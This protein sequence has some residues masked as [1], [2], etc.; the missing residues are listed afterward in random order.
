MP[1]KEP[2]TKKKSNNSRVIV[3]AVLIVVVIGGGI[4]GSVYFAASSKTVYIDNAQI[5]APVVD[6]GPNS[7]GILQAVYVSEGDVVAPNTVVAEVGT[8]LIKTTQGGLVTLVNNNVGTTVNPGDTVVETLDPTTLRVVGQIQEDKGLV[9]IVPGDQ[10]SFEVDAFG[11]KKYEG[12][13][14]EVAPEAQSSDVVFNISDQREEQ[15]F[16]VKVRFDTT[17][18]PELKNGMSARIWVYKN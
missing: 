12:V 9:D 18:Y 2:K 13:V 17:A 16:D 4:G 15:D 6:L 5:E 7:S 11:G 1:E 14:D 8:E 3:L 10:V